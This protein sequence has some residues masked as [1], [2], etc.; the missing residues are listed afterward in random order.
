MI[1]REIHL[2]SSRATKPF[3][4]VNC[5][6]IPDTLIESELFG[7]EKGAFTNA[8]ARR[9]GKLE[10]ADNGTLFLDEIADMSLN[11]QAK[12]LR[13][14]QEMQ[15]ERVGGE[16]SIEV[17]V[18]II[19]ATNKDISS[20]I[21][22]GRFREDLFFRLNVVPIEVPALRARL[23]DIEPLVEYFLGK[24]ANGEDIQLKSISAKGMD[25]LRAYLWPGNIRELKNFIE[26]ISIMAD[27][28]IVSEDEVRQYLGDHASFLSEEDVSLSSYTDMNLAEAKNE[29]EKKLIEMKL[30]DSDFNI[31]KAA[32]VLGIYPSNLHGKI[33][34]LGIQ[35]PK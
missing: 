5:A 6:A 35:V 24:Y 1:A 25:A 4:E 30:R 19:A 28:E 17:N 16:Q 20:E 14:M 26:R 31:S 11:A 3:I 23:E 21:K 9:K 10:L 12:V 33:K 22:S 13:V 34:K 2:R 27:G 7:H 15:F 32:E 18:R 29:F 8:V